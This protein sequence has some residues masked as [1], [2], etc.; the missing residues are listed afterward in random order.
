MIAIKYPT[1]SVGRM[2]QYTKPGKYTASLTGVAHNGLVGCLGDATT[3]MTIEDGM[4]GLVIKPRDAQVAKVDIGGGN[5]FAPGPVYLS[6]TISLSHPVQRCMVDVTV[7][8]ANEGTGALNV[9]V[10]D[11]LIEPSWTTGSYVF[12]PDTMLNFPNSGKFRIVAK[13]R[14]NYQGSQCGGSA[15]ADFEIKRTAIHF[16]GSN[17]PAK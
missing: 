15:H 5:V 12:K 13:G 2:R 14:L 1:E 8:T 6:A 3:T 10:M 9:V 17:G 11:Q 4:E 7:E 16:G